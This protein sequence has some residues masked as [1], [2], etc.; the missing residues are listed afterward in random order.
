MQQ[1]DK[2]VAAC[3]S[4]DYSTWPYTQ[5][6]RLARLDKNGAPDTSFS[7]SFGFTNYEAS[8]LLL[9]RDGGILIGALP[10]YASTFDP[11]GLF[12]FRSDGS[13][14]PAFNPAV[15][16]W[17]NGMA[18]QSDGKIVVAGELMTTLPNLRCRVARLDSAGNVDWVVPLESGPDFSPTTVALDANG[19]ILVGGSFTNVGPFHRRGIVRLIGS[20]P[21]FVVI[22]RWFFEGQAFVLSAKTDPGRNYFLEFKETAAD[23]EWAVVSSVAG[24]GNIQDFRDPGPAGTG[25]FYRIRA[26]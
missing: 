17:I 5:T 15:R 10:R 25:R 19:S 22:S 1:D 2:I 18:V 8:G 23:P 3:V 4:T 12:R 16:G 26:E 7:S 11:R 14:D 20:G 9:Q 21:S 24:N 13:L 6:Y